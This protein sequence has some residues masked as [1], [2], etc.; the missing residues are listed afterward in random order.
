MK[1]NNLSI[2]FLETLIDLICKKTDR[3]FILMDIIMKICLMNL[4]QQ[5]MSM[6]MQTYMFLYMTKN[7]ILLIY[8]IYLLFYN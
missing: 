7:C 3:D 2:R 8:L 4:L 5:Q 1:N 6:Q